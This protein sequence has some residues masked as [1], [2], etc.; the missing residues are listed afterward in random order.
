[1]YLLTLLSSIP[2][3]NSGHHS[4][5]PVDEMHQKLTLHRLQDLLERFAE[6]NVILV[7]DF[8]LN[9]QIVVDCQRVETIADTD[10]Q[11][12]Q[13][14]ESRY[15]L[16]GAG[17]VANILHSLG[18]PSVRLFG[19]VGSD[20]N[21]W[22]ML[23]LLQAIG[24]DLNDLN[25]APTWLTPTSILHVDSQGADDSR[26]AV[27]Q[28]SQR[29]DI[30]MRQALSDTHLANA[31]TRL[32]RAIPNC[33]LVIVMDQFPE[34]NSGYFSQNFRGFLSEQADTY[35]QQVFC[36]DSRYFAGQYTHMNSII[37]ASDL[38]ANSVGDGAKSNPAKSTE[39]PK[40]ANAKTSVHVYE[41]LQGAAIKLRRQL[42]KPVLVSLGEKGILTCDGATSVIPPLTLSPP[43]DRMGANECITAVA[44]ASIATGASAI[45][46]AQVAIL[47]SNLVVHQFAT[48]G[49][50]SKVDL[51][52][53]FQSMNR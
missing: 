36:V 6:L 25:V 16:G 24:C 46:A 27:N 10:K 39:K 49:K 11:A 38:L 12:H 47:A 26:L 29:F 19:A 42:L 3:A 34:E 30:R 7:G 22:Q 28:P 43:I 5:I 18:V 2:A 8:I 15:S 40:Q 14:V 53:R 35:R 37:N 20:G 45:E 17:A 41:E 52:Q 44:A 32:A 21:G 31:S 1:M 51:I 48:P 33:D 13:V 23:K 50:V 4:Q 9:Q